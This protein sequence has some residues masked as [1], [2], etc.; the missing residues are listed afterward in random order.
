MDL[1]EYLTTEKVRQKF[2]SQFDLVNYSIKLAANMIMTGRDS[3]VKTDTQSRA[4]Q[5]L[6]EILNGKD[7]FDDVISTEK[8]KP[9]EPRI[10]AQSFADIDEDD[11]DEIEEVPVKEKKKKLR[12][13]A[14]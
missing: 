11:E 10:T 7:K 5:V 6:N 3:R 2:V 8:V 13:T 4:I 1:K 9:I 14:V 12:K